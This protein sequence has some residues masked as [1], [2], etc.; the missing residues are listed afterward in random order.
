MEKDGHE[1]IWAE[2]SN[3]LTNDWR[4]VRQYKPDCV[5]IHN[6]NMRQHILLSLYAST[7]TELDDAMEG[8]FKHPVGVDRELLYL[9]LIED[10]DI[11]TYVG[12]LC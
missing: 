5:F 12:T 6:L 9:L 3:Q 7:Y 2:E 8:R 1:V 10:T 4:L 11:V